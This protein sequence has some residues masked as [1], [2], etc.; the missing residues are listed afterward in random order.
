VTSSY[1][2]VIRAFGNNT[3]IEVPAEILTQLGTGKRPKVL[4]S[5]DDYRFATTLGVMGGLVLIPLSK[6]RREASGL[7]AGQQVHVSLE[8]D[9]IPAEIAV[10]PDLAAALA[11][12][13]IGEAFEKLAPSRRK[14]FARQVNDAKAEQT[15]ARRIAKIIAELV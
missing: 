15:R 6:A 11:Q 7:S 14:E 2:T 1:D 12:A 4:V 8:L 13:E 3:G 10:P 5:V 9:T